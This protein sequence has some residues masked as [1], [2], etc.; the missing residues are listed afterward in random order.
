MKFIRN[1]SY[2]IRLTPY[3]DELELKIGWGLSQCRYN[4]YTSNGQLT[5]CHMTQTEARIIQN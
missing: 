5:V 4:I 2:Q 1:R 3:F